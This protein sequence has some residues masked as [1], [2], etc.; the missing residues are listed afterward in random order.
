MGYNDLMTV[1]R[2]RSSKPL[3]QLTKLEAEIESRKRAQEKMEEIEVLGQKSDFKAA[4]EISKA[5]KQLETIHSAEW[6]TDMTYLAHFKTHK[7][8]YNRYLAVIL[9]RFCSE[10]AVPNKYGIEV[11]INDIGVVLNI[12]GTNYVGAFKASGMPSFD[13]NAC[14]ILAVKMGNTIAKL[15]G[16]SRT[17]DQGI[18]LVDDQDIKK[19]G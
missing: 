7:V 8:Q 12:K 2:G 17:T 13:R 1:I 5:D 10:E 9:H 4:K 11:E 14:K 3:K 16:Y 6:E 15:E 18:I 19:Y